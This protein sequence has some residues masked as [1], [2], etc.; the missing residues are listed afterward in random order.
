MRL[1]LSLALLLSLSI[2]TLAAPTS[3][4]PQRRKRSFQVE[5]V[6][7]NDYVA[8]GP[9]ALRKAYRKFG[10]ASTNFTGIELDDFEPFEIKTSAVSTN[11]NSATTEPD[12]TGAVSA[13]SVQSDVEFV[14]PVTIGG[15]TITMDF[16]TGSSDMYASPIDSFEELFPIWPVLLKKT[17]AD[18]RWVMN[19]ELPES[20]IQG[21]TVYDPSSSTTFKKVSGGSFKISYGD[22][23]SASGGLGKDTV[24]IGGATVT[25][26]TF[27]LPTSVSES[28][29]EDTYSNGLVGLG[30][31]SINTFDPGPQKTFFDNIASDLE[32][33]VLTARLRSDSVGEYEFGKI[34][35]SK[36]TGTLVNV[37]VDSS[38][39]FWQFK[40]GYYAVGSGAL[41]EVTDIPNAIVDTGTSLMLVSPEVAEAYY[42]EVTS[43]AYSSSVA[44]YIYPCAADLPSLTVALGDKY[45]ATI[46]GSLINFAEVGTNKTTGDTVCY[47][48]IQSNSGSSLQIFGDVFLKALF[49][50]FDQ[51]GPSL[52]FASPS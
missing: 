39:G 11:Q 27:G 28:F 25:G 32:E 46:P 34:D 19:T 44:G 43:A 40:A 52:G 24:D 23:S 45:Q 30:F 4:H 9:H 29:I 3:L 42:S 12:Q 48:G 33:P 14:S 26:Q 16:D 7:R 5:R 31:S 6:K 51:R 37:T 38:N 35:E 21:R 41:H 1:F 50:V 8:H 22:S 20:T 13:T 49:V 15:Q 36:Y 2:D 47:G 17:N 10:I 18:H